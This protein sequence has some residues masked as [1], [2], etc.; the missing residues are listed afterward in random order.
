MGRSSERAP[1]PPPHRT[2]KIRD[3]P[4]TTGWAPAGA[5]APG[6]TRV[7]FCELTSLVKTAAEEQLGPPCC[8]WPM[9]GRARATSLLSCR[10]SPGT[11][12]CWVRFGWCLPAERLHRAKYADHTPR[13]R[14]RGSSHLHAHRRRAAG[15]G[16]QWGRGPRPE[17][18]WP[19]HDIGCDATVGWSSRHGCRPRDRIARKP[20]T[21]W[22]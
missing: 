18:R 6:L 4:P 19:M 13:P 12:G 3:R 17:V 14:S 16:T 15:G 20:A 5:H 9:P 7:A 22:Q 11:P 2:R 21:R 8:R 1:S 10:W